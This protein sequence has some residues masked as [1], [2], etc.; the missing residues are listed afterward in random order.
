MATAVSPRGRDAVVRLTHWVL[1]VAVLGAW[2]T[3]EVDGW[4]GVHMTLGYTA[5]GALTARLAWALLS[6]SAGLGRWLRMGAGLW[7][8]LQ[9]WVSGRVGVSAWMTQALGATVVV[10]M[11]LVAL[12]VSTGAGMDLGGTRLDDTAWGEWLEEWHEGLGNALLL[13]VLGHLGVVLALSVVRRRMLAMDLVRSD[14]GRGA[15]AWVAR[16]VALCLVVALAGFWSLRWG[17]HGPDMVRDPVQGVQHH[18]HGHSD[19]HDG[20]DD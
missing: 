18:E 3:S 11:I 20:D 14:A 9:A 7:R 2:L 1:A 6:P 10:L 5:A 19:D 8:G 17:S 16:S 12:T 13:A 15:R 4:R